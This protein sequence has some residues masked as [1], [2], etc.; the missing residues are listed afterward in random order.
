MIEVGE[1]QVRPSSPDKVLFPQSGRRKRDVVDY[2]L[3]VAEPTLVQLRDRPCVLKRFPNGVE[4]PFFFQKRT[5]PIRPAGRCCSSSG[6]GRRAS[7]RRACRA[8][9]GRR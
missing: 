8:G 4:Q 7:A 5:A 2:Y 1:R 6:R 3:A 9:C